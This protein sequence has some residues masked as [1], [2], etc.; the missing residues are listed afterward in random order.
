M[1]RPYV[2]LGCA[3]ALYG[4]LDFGH[5]FQPAGEVPVVLAQE[6]HA[7]REED[8]AD[9]SGV[10]E[11]GG[12]EAEAKLLEG[13]VAGE[14]EDDGDGAHDGGGVADGAGRGLDADG[15]GLIVRLAVLVGLIDT[16]HADHVVVHREPE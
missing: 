8:G 10:D 15:D 4:H 14:G 9:D 3:S 13:D 1:T 16:A 11:D 6:L 5:P 2:D 7:G 12:G